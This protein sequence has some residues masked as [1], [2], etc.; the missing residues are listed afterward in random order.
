MI[1]GILCTTPGGYIG[2]DDVIPWHHSG[3]LKRFAR[4]TKDQAVL[5]GP[6]TFL[7]IAKHYRKSGKQVLPGREIIVVGSPRHS[8]HSWNADLRSVDRMLHELSVEL[9]HEVPLDNVKTLIPSDPGSDL[10]SA[11]ALVPGKDLFIAG[12]GTIYDRY[13]IYAD[14]IHL[15]EVDFENFEVDFHPKAVKLSG[16]VMDLLASLDRLPEGTEVDAG[17]TASYFLLS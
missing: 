4:L 1:K 16:R 13:L 10:K 3:D 14:Q 7:G 6:K 12:G 9:R 11:Q 17:I 8:I 5:M 15:T 2:H